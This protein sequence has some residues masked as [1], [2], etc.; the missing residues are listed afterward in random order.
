MADY[1]SLREAGMDVDSLSAEEQAALANL[2]QS[3]VDALAS[4]KNKLNGEDE[5]GG[6]S[7]KRSDDGNIVW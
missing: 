4:I 1:T 7:V 3:E 6:F 5:V 2:D